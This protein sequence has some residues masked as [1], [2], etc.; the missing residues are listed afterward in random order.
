MWI[1]ESFTAYSENLFLD[2]HY[3]K[4]AS[5]EYVIGTRGGIGNRRPI[6]GQYNVNSEGSDDMYYKGANMLHTIR[7]LVND[8]E[9]WRQILRGLNKEFYHQ[10]V[11]THQIESYIIEKSGKDLASVFDQYLRDYRVPVLEYYFKEGNLMYRW[12]NAVG[13]FNMPVEVTMGGK[14]FVLTPTTGWKSM[15]TAGN[16]LIVDIDYYVA[17]F[18]V[19]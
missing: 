8:D 3:G 14:E 15:E 2:Y 18:K 4:K 16:E 9:K 5:A 13:N 7:Q 10:T 1:H 11:T 12:N 6:I 17:S 19:Q